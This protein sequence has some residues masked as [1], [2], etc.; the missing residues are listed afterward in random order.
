M[1]S[2]SVTSSF[3]NFPHHDSNFNNTTEDNRVA[4]SYR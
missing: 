2:G 3:A 4:V 1:K